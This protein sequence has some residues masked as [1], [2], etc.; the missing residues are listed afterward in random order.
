MELKSYGLDIGYWCAA[1]VE[2]VSR[3]LLGLMKKTGC[4]FINYGFESMD[5]QVLKIMNK[6]T[7][8]GARSDAAVTT[9]MNGWAPKISMITPA[10]PR[11]R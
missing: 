2:N 11:A 8:P 10:R 7:T 3:E 1:R 6:N 9:S 5:A 4:R